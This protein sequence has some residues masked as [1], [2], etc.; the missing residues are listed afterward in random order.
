MTTMANNNN[1]NDNNN[2][3][4]DISLAICTNIFKLQFFSSSVFFS[5][6]SFPYFSLF[7]SFVQSPVQLLI[8]GAAR[9]PSTV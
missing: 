1:D 9:P 2:K 4:F 5:S 6:P 7:S 3:N 8:G